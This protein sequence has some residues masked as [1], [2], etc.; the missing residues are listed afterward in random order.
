MNAQTAAVIDFQAP[1]SAR[2]R[3]SREELDSVPFV[4]IRVTSRLSIDAIAKLNTEFN[5]CLRGFKQ[6][7]MLET[8]CRN[9]GLMDEDAKAHHALS[10]EYKFKG[11][12]IVETLLLI[13]A[14]SLTERR[15]LLSL[16][17]E[18]FDLFDDRQAA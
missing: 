9:A 2:P 8:K 18:Q 13:G 3:L 12:G 5:E 10:Q 4:S 6:H 1:R 16:L 17:A 15:R 7:Q 14:I 11:L